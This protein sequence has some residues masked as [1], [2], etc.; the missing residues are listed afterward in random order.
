MLLFTYHVGFEIEKGPTRNKFANVVFHF[1]NLVGGRTN[2]TRQGWIVAL[3]KAHG[4]QLV[5]IVDAN[6][7]VHQTSRHDNAFGIQGLIGGEAFDLG[8]YEASRVTSGGRTDTLIDV[9]RFLF[10]TNVSL[11]IRRGSTNDG[12]VNWLGAVKQ[13]IFSVKID[14]GD[15]LE[16]TLTSLIVGATTTEIRVL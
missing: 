14:F 6:Y 3:H 11:S 8:N 2:D 13:L 15:G 10:N 1:G 12:H 16:G 5:W 7:T 4:V 9:Q